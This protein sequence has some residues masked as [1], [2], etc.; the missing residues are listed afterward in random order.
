[1]DK[2]FIELLF[3]DYSADTDCFDYKRELV[4]F[5]GENPDSIVNAHVKQQFKDLIGRYISHS[6]S[7]RYDDT[8]KTILLTYIVFSDYFNFTFDSSLHLEDID[9]S[10]GT[11]TN[12]RPQ[13]VQF[14]Q[15]LSHGLRHVAYLLKS[16]QA[17]DW[18]QYATLEKF[19]SIKSEYAGKI[20]S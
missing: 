20:D 2:T 14:E 12:P 8:E 3:V 13:K 16:N 7:W 4:P 9:L 17:P 1:M 6:T 5:G 11:W 18:M 15:V 10:H 19:M